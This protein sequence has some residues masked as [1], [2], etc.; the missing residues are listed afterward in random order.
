MPV[1]DLSRAVWRKSSYSN[2]SG[3]SCVEIATIPP[4]STHLGGQTSTEIAVPAGQAD[5]GARIVAVRDSKDRQGPVLVF[6]PADWQTFAGA[7]KAG[8]FDLG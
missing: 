2:G 3:G 4:N 6:S 8:Q 1:P 5:S 7:V